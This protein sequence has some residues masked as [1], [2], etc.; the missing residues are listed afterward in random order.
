MNRA[1]DAHRRETNYYGDIQN[2]LEF[3]KE[4]NY[5]S[6]ILPMWLVIVNKRGWIGDAWN[7]QL[8]QK[9]E[10][11][12][13]LVQKHIKLEWEEREVLTLDLSHKIVELTWA[14]SKVKNE[15]RTRERK[16]K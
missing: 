2:I 14:I 16:N 12:Y 6:S 7:S 5:K 4:Q 13:M 15:A 11:N 10:P 1:I 3:C 8:K 9:L